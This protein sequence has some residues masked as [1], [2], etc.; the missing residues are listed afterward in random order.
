M[1][2]DQEQEMEDWYS[3]NVNSKILDIILLS[4]MLLPFL[5]VLIKQQSSGTRLCLLAFATLNLLIT[6]IV[7]IFRIVE[8]FKKSDWWTEQISPFTTQNG[9]QENRE[10]IPD[11]QKN[12][13]QFVIRSEDY[14][15]FA[16][17]A[18]ALFVLSSIIQVLSLVIFYS[19]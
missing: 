7:W 15:I 2:E 4:L 13:E 5:A 9:L 10:T 19:F 14:K 3:S 17:V 11:F 16:Y 6:I 8:A 18:I 1:N 12:D